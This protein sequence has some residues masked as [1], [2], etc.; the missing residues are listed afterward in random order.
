MTWEIWLAYLA[1]VLVLMGTPGPSQL[2]ML[3]NSLSQGFGTSAANP[4]AVVFFAALFPQFIDPSQPLW[5]QFAYLS[6][7]YLI[8]DGTTL[9]VYGLF[10][11][12]I[13][14]SLRPTVH[15]HLNKISG[16]LLIGSALLLGLKDAEHR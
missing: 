6:V 10:A 1:T 13:N 11:Q 4:K 9:S 15:K 2:L 12:W 5:E 16:A 3:S 7:T 14:Q 8:L